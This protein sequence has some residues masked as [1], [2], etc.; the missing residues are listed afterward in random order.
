MM[1]S[2]R[3][4]AQGG[5]G[6]HFMSEFDGEPKG[7]LYGSFVQTRRVVMLATGSPQLY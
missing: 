2:P 3:V 4:L 1:F 5:E 7:R 6:A